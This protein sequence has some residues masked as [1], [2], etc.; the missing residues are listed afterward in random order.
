MLRAAMTSR[1]AAPKLDRRSALALGAAL[2]VP[3]PV[4]ANEAQQH[5]LD[6]GH[7]G[8]RSGH[9]DQT[10]A[11][12]RAI[13][14][15]AQ[16]KLPL[17]LPPGSYRA[18]ALKVPAGVQLVGARG[19][20]RLVL[21]K[22]MPLL[23]ASGENVTL[24][25][26]VI[27]GG[28]LALPESTG[29]IQFSGG[30]DLHINDCEVANAGGTAILCR[31][32]QGQITNTTV[33]DAADTAIFSI[34]GINMLI[35]GNTIRNSGNG[36][37]RVWQSKPNPDGT[38]VVDNHIENTGAKAGGSG[39]N[40]NAINVYRA[41][42]VIVRGNRID[43]TAFSAV[44]GNAASQM[45]IVANNCT[46]IGEVALYAE[47]EFENAVINGNTVDGA[48]LGIAVTNFKQGGRLA[49]VQGNV[50]RNIT[51]E[52]PAG[53]DPNDG[54][55]IGIG[56]EADTAVTGNVIENASRVGI[57]VGNGPYLRDVTVTGNI[58]RAAP[59]GITVSVATGAAAA[60]ISQNLITGARRGAIVGM[61]WQ[62][63]VTT[64][65]TLVAPGAYPQLTI[66]GNQVR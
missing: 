27:D 50:L 12:Q 66:T 34:D 3:A 24:N 46:D 8:V 44:R 20:S 29:L 51:R 60:V 26:L 23:S 36:G 15:A 65:L 54:Y 37:I 11:L 41:A 21:A 53:T 1:I 5:G 63:V 33:A 56:V 28:H 22:S 10:R 43:K 62:K 7:L 58:V 25:G 49:T 59:T 39:Q 2:L 52:R 47:F 18:A 30:R 31:M 14:Q 64:D 4:S 35:A 57:A 38:I 48:A 55:G 19:A 40:G 42:N 9:D 17:W 6:A 13:D 61:D 45:Q 16:K 32:S